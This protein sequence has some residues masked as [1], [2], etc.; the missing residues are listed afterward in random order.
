MEQNQ[1]AAAF[2]LSIILPKSDFFTDANVFFKSCKK[3]HKEL[4]RNEIKLHNHYT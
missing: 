2:F 4:S 3:N 1:S